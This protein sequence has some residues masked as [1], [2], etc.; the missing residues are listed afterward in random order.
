MQSKLNQRSNVRALS[1]AKLRWAETRCVR[2]MR[3]MNTTMKELRIYCSYHKWIA[4]LRRRHSAYKDRKVFQPLIRLLFLLFSSSIFF[5]NKTKNCHKIDKNGIHMVLGV[6]F[7]LLFP[8]IAVI[9][10]HTFS[11][12]ADKLTTDKYER[13]SFH[14][15][16]VFVRHIC[17]L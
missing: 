3:R 6:F 11:Y 8:S 9:R 5:K 10:V 16:I 1:R 17:W 2:H 14:A 4:Q 15:H 12:T 13:K 7:L